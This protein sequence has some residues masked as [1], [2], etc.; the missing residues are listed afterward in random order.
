MSE[1]SKPLLFGNTVKPGDRSGVSE[2]MQGLRFRN[3]SIFERFSGSFVNIP[4]RGYRDAFYIAQPT[5]L[6][7]GVL[8]VMVF[9]FIC[10]FV[11]IFFDMSGNKDFIGVALGLPW[12]FMAAAWVFQVWENRGKDGEYT[13]YI[14]NNNDILKN[15]SNLNVT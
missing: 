8:V 15:T 5:S 11:A 6:M 9:S 2:E 4:E 13:S 14:K 3:P 12:A 7:V 1:E 10:M